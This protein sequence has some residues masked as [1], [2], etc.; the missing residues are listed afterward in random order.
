[1]E[2]VIYLGRFKR[3]YPCK[4]YFIFYFSEIFANDLIIAQLCIY[5]FGSDSPLR[6][7]SNLKK[8]RPIQKI[9]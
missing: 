3:N 1:M 6:Y 5:Q 2:E 8:E 4:R 9:N 7:V